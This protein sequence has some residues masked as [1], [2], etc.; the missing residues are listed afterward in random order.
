MRPTSCAKTCGKNSSADGRH[1]YF[2]RV[3]E[4]GA[5]LADGRLWLTI[6]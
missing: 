1:Y 3:T 4:L 6:R 5:A 2:R